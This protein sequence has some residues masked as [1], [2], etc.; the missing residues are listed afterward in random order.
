MRVILTC[1]EDHE[2]DA[3]LDVD[4]PAVGTEPEGEEAEGQQHQD[5]A[6][7]PQTLTRLQPVWNNK[8]VNNKQVKIA[9]REI[10]IF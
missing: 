1:D 2:D 10:A 8:P 5:E 9:Y 3:D 4:V 6:Q 7:H